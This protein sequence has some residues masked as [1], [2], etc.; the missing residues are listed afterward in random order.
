MA[1][2]LDGFDSLT[3]DAPLSQQLPGFVLHGEE[4]ISLVAGRNH[5]GKA[6]KLT[7]GAY[8]EYHIN[9]NG[10]YDRTVNFGC[11]FRYTKK[12]DN[13]VL[14]YVCNSSL[15]SISTDH[16]TRYLDNGSGIAVLYAKDGFLWAA[17][18]GAN[19]QFKL[20][21]FPENQYTYIEVR[22]AWE[23]TTDGYTPHSKVYMNGQ[24]LVTFG[25]LSYGYSKSYVSVYIGRGMQDMTMELDDLYIES[26]T[27]ATNGSV[28]VLASGSVSDL[29]LTAESNTFSV[30]GE[31]VESALSDDSDATYIS[32]NEPAEVV[33]NVERNVPQIYGIQMAARGKSE[34]SGVTSFSLVD[35]A[36]ANIIGE[37]NVGFPATFTN[38]Y[39]SPSTANSTTTDKIKA[40]AKF[41]VRT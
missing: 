7:N 19:N 35:N 15:P 40:G 16:E 29:A 1:L 38:Y 27:S 41:K 17:R 5:K 2:V 6:L 39:L 18:P 26:Y 9:G 8:L 33:F 37:Q 14:V 28:P 4:N 25:Q 13:N 22:F 11:A 23:R 36:G 3:N 32:S 12:T 31:S 24:E 34:T 21:K 10:S 20:A 30:T